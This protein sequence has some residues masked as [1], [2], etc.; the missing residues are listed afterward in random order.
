MVRTIQRL[1]AALAA[2]GILLGAWAFWFEP[3][4]LVVHE[5]ELEL[6]GLPPAH[7]GLRV[8]LLADLH[9]GSPR[10]DLAMLRRIV[11]RVNAAHPDL[12]LFL[13]DLVIQGVKGGVFVSPEASAAELSRLRA[14]YGVYGVLGNHDW[15]LD[16]RRVARALEGAG[17]T[18]LE[19]AS[20]PIEA[21]GASLWLAGVSDLTE[22]PHDLARALAGIPADRPV[23]LLTHH[24]DL[25]PDVPQRVT[26]TVAGHTHGGQVSLPFFGRPI[27]PS[28]YGERYAAGHVVEAGKH[29]FVCT[30]TGT[31]I[32]PVR[33]RV[34]PEIALL[35]LRSKR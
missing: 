31:S 3:G 24:P 23:I 22:G 17:M 10:H 19:D 18:L 14:R 25:F 7:D 12:V 26:L 20:T 28:A 35:T 8:A 6:P 32:L 33:F 27:V 30:G 11:D 5:A 29:L 9:V 4:R 2:S 16:A 21:K 1:I 15:W 13:G 34:P